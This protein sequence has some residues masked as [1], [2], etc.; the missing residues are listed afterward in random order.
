M[1]TKAMQAKRLDVLETRELNR[2]GKNDQK[3]ED[4]CNTELRK[5]NLAIQ[6]VKPYP[7]KKKAA[8]KKKVETPDPLQ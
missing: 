3:V 8:P 7:T 6:G 4:D 5:L 1:D 2:K